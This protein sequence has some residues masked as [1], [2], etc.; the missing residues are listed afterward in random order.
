M[1]EGVTHFLGGAASLPCG[2]FERQQRWRGAFEADEVT[3]FIGAGLHQV[4]LMHGRP[5]RMS[6]WTRC[7]N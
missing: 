3:N 6:L 7:G 2:C 4:A 1:A 5:V